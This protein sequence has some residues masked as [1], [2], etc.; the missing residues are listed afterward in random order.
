MKKLLLMFT[1]LLSATARADDVSMVVTRGVNHADGG[2]LGA[3]AY[4]QDL[5]DQLN[6]WGLLFI[7]EQATIYTQPF[8]FVGSIGPGFE[9]PLPYNTFIR[10]TAGV[11]GMTRTNDELS[12]YF[13]FI[14]KGGA[15]IKFN[16]LGNQWRIGAVYQHYSS[17][18]IFKRNSGL[19]YVGI[20]FG[21]ELP[22]EYKFAH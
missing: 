14:L 17:A 16:A 4:S 21:V 20:E 12:G 19:D 6:P 1:L 2:Y 15:G 11:S 8:T 9:L 7:E 10:G 18:G 3:L 5:P 22:E 13:Q